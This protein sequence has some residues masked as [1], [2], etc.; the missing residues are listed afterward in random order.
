MVQ[1]G[2]SYPGSLVLEG[3]CSLEIVRNSEMY[4]KHYTYFYAMPITTPSFQNLIEEMALKAVPLREVSITY[5][6]GS[7]VRMHLVRVCQLS[8]LCCAKRAPKS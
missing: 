3:V 6:T 1:L 8:L 2:L 5:M 4:S 7:E